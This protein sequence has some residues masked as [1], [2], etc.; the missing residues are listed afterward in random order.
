MI[1][2]FIVGGMCLGIIIALCQ[3]GMFKKRKK[4]EQKKVEK[5]KETKPE[6]VKKEEQ[7]AKDR[8]FNIVK[9]SRLSRISK[10][11]LSTD[12]RTGTV[13]RVFALT[14]EVPQEEHVYI[15]SLEQQNEELLQAVKDVD[16]E[17]KKVVSIT[18]LKQ[19]AEQQTAVEEC[20]TNETVVAEK[21]DAGFVSGNYFGVHIGSSKRARVEKINIDQEHLDEEETISLNARFKNL[22]K[23]GTDLAVQGSDRFRRPGATEDINEEDEDDGINLNDII[24]ADAILNPKYK[25]KK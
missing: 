1:Y 22:F 19:K 14:P 9:K 13:E 12:S 10:K 24:I 7:P 2:Y 8:S 15:D 21:T 4:P 17:G 20:D 16:T 11:A 25:K 23:R 3:A 6:E 18:E 5:P